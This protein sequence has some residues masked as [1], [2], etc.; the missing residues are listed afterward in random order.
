M[1]QSG[2]EMA[3]SLREQEVHKKSVNTSFLRGFLQP[4]QHLWVQRHS[5]VVVQN[6]GKSAKRPLFVTK[7]EA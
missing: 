5:P 4:D 6:C 7:L 3:T 1:A 2:Q